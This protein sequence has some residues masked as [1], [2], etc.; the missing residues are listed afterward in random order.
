M[1][2]RQDAL[3]ALYAAQAKPKIE[4][5]ADTT[6]RPSSAGMVGQVGA[7]FSRVRDRMAAKTA[8]REIAPN[9]NRETVYDQECRL[10][11][12]H[13]ADVYRQQREAE[14]E[15][16]QEDERK[17]R[18]AA[19]RRAD[20]D[21]QRRQ[22]EDMA[23]TLRKAQERQSEIVVQN[24]TKSEIRAI[25]AD[26]S[27]EEIQEV[28]QRVDQTKSAGIPFMYKAHLDEVRSEQRR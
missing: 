11:G 18:E 24:M 9:P 14:A 13:W 5:E 17:Q 15:E 2:S 1:P 21:R 10:F 6:S 23:R 20:E 28:L 12:K 26:A 16:K 8:S 3:T 7:A 4:I 19:E 27:A 22:A 25:L